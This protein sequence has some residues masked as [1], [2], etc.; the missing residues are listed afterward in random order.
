MLLSKGNVQVGSPYKYTDVVMGITLELLSTM[1]RLSETNQSVPLSL[2][3]ALL[4]FK[5]GLKT[6]NKGIQNSESKRLTILFN[7]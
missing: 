7:T 3:E 6:K 4:W 1:C 5:P 2:S